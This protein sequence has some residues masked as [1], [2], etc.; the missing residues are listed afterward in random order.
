M[1]LA[2]TSVLYTFA[3]FEQKW[4]AGPSLIFYVP[5][6]GT[7]GDASGVVGDVLLVFEGG[8]LAV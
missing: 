7:E 1:D 2:R 5:Y 3:S 6:R 8:L 4:Y